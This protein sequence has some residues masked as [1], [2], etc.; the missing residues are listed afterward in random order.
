[1]LFSTATCRTRLIVRGT[2]TLQILRF[3]LQKHDETFLHTSE[4]ARCCTRV[5]SVTCDAYTPSR[6]TIRL[7][8]Y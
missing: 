7:G 4:A 8:A 3:K 5:L 2:F 6:L 1:M